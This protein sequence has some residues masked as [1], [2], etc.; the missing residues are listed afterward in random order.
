MFHKR[1]LLFFVFILIGVSAFSQ[2]TKIIDSLKKKLPHVNRLEKIAVLNDLSWELAPVDPQLALEYSKTALKLCKPDETENLAQTYVV[3]GG[4]YDFM[5]K[6][7][8]ARKYYDL[9]GKLR[10][11]IQDTAGYSNTL[12]NI[13]VTYYYQGLY[14]KALEYYIKS[15]H[16]KEYTDDKQGLSKLYN[17]IGLIYRVKKNHPM[18]IRYFRKSL[19][20]KMELGDQK[21]VCNSYS[22]IGI[23]YLYDNVCDSAIYY[24]RKAYDIAKA[25]HSPYDEAS[26]LS[27]VAFSYLCRRDFKKADYYFNQTLKQ[28]VPLSDDHTMAFCFKG[29]GESKFLQGKYQE[30]ISYFEKAAQKA[31]EM[32]RQELLAEIYKYQFRAYENMGQYQKS[33]EAYKNHVSYR[34]SVFS[35]ENNQQLN[36]LEVSFETEKKQQRI[37]ELS[38]LNKL[39]NEQAA[40]NR[41][42]LN[43]LIVVVIAVLLILL[44]TYVNLRNKK[45]LNALLDSK[46]QMIETSLKEKE[47]LLREIHHRV[48]NNLQIISGLL[49]LQESLH[50]DENV[51]SVVHEAQGRIKTMSIIH[52]MLYQTDDLAHIRFSDYLNRLV[53]AIHGGFSQQKW[54]VEHE[55]S[56]GGQTFSIDTIIPLGLMLNELVSNSYKYAFS[57]DKTNK[58]TVKLQEIAPGEFQMNYQDNGPGMPEENSSLESQSFG[59]K[60]VKMLTRQLRGN[61][62]YQYNAG[63]EFIIKFKEITK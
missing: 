41:W 25:I 23:I 22:N 2:E 39:R 42:Q 52:E 38:S 49:E 9:G 57:N 40:R 13:G 17:N 28:L 47:V 46:N 18:A 6:Y 26:S 54:Q 24:T 5:G 31:K 21:G 48:K 62:S 44:L 3:L 60:L 63:S 58:L 50:N 55:I 1:I 20:I 29:M 37:K 51:K 10:L 7:E 35:E 11:Q 19:A 45:R 30:S 8:E 4:A 15:S 34:D 32:N 33:L 59:L 27:N 36:E 56:D 53:Q 16:W 12:L 43:A 61:V 14:N